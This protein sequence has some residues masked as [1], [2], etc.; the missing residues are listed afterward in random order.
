MRLLHADAPLAAR[1]FA[2]TYVWSLWLLAVALDPL[3]YLALLPATSFEPA[4]LA[5]FVPDT[6]RA[7]LLSTTGILLLKIV[8]L[9]AIGLAASGIWRRPAAITACLLLTVQQGMVRGFG[10]INHAEITLL[11][12]AYIVTWFDCVDFTAGIAKP[13]VKASARTKSGG[14]HTAAA[15]LTAIV[16]MLCVT[17]MFTGMHRVMNG[18]W[19]VFAGNHLENWMTFAQHSP[20]GYDLGLGAWLLSFD[21]FRWSMIIGFPLVTLFEILAPLCLVSRRFRVVFVAVMLPFHLLVL[22]T[23]GIV[24]WQSLA[25]YIFFLDTPF[26]NFICKNPRPMH[27]K[28]WITARQTAA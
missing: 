25:L 20:R 1:D 16:L 28:G 5:A 9:L 22:A 8:S 10:H 2:R 14:R 23:M 11:M 4:G 19:H 27:W 17:Y 24:F 26:W 15:P 7:A 18:G 6:L 12:S 3:A 21:L 13:D